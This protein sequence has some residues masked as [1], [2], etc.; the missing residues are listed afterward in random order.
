VPSVSPTSAAAAPIPPIPAAQSAVAADR[1]EIQA[2]ADAWLEV[3]DANGSILLNRTLHPGDTWT[4]PQHAGLVL[5]T[6]NAGGTVLV[7]DGVAAPA[8]GNSGAVRRNLPLDPDL[9]RE[10]KLAGAA[11]SSV[12]PAS[13]RTNGQ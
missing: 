9:I 11:A 7:V 5:T 8:L 6:G 12:Q 2:T 4:V 3:R 13:L 10:G 1:V